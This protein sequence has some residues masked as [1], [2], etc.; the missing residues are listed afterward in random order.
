[1]IGIPPIPHESKTFEQIVQDVLAR[2]RAETS[3]TLA[4]RA[5]ISW[6]MLGR[7]ARAVLAA[8]GDL[9]PDDDLLVRIVDAVRAEL[10]GEES[11]PAAGFATLLPGG[12]EASEARGQAELVRSSVLPAQMGDQRAAFEALGFRF[13][14]PVDGDP[15]FIHALLPPGWSKA[16]SDHDMWSHVLDEKGRKRAAVF[17][18]AAF[19]DR[20]AN[21]SLVRRYS[22]E[23]EYSKPSYDIVRV[24]VADG[25]TGDEIWSQAGGTREAARA[26]LDANRPDHRDVV[27]SW[28][29]T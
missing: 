6:T 9:L 11:A 16:P 23:C 4:R 5:G 2:V 19:Y 12:I 13:G 15:L 14:E 7:Y 25:A 24:W 18:K 29:G 17:Y 1:M 10:A 27:A 8:D 26:W 21:M 3:G 20:R 22:I 28:S